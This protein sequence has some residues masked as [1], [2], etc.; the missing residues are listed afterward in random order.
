MLVTVM[1]Y[2]LKILVIGILIDYKVGLA[3][4]SIGHRHSFPPTT[5]AFSHSRHSSCMATQVWE[6]RVLWESRREDTWLRPLPGRLPFLLPCP[7]AT[8]CVPSPPAPAT[9]CGQEVVR[10]MRKGPCVCSSF[11]VS[12]NKC[13]FCLIHHLFSYCICQES[14]ISLNIRI[15]FL[16]E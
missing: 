1:S 11:H 12:E 2:I 16:T 10:V 4:A 7:P 3:M 13:A 6:V 15:E 9:P 8:G 14:A 5:P